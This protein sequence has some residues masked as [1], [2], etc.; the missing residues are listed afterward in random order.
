MKR[1]FVMSIL[2]ALAGCAGAWSRPGASDADLTKDQAEC[3]FE[4]KKATGNNPDAIAAGWNEGQLMTA[5]LK[6]KGWQR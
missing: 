2:L 5:C 6:A 4:A 3:D 1:A